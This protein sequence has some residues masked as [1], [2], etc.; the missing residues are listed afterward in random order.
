[1]SYGQNQLFHAIE[2]SHLAGMIAQELHA[3]VNIARG[4][5]TP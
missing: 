4:G 5:L 1:M 2:T 3:N